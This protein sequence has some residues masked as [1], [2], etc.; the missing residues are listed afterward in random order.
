VRSGSRCCTTVPI[1]LTRWRSPSSSRG[2]SW[3]GTS[4]TVSSLSPCHTS[5]HPRSGESVTHQRRVDLRR[6]TGHDPQPAHPKTLLRSQRR[7]GPEIIG[8]N[9]SE[10]VSSALSL[11]RWRIISDRTCR[12][13]NRGRAMAF[14]STQISTINL[15]SITHDLDSLIVSS[16]QHDHSESNQE[17]RGGTARTRGQYSSSRTW[18]PSSRIG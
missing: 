8:T 18:P 5:R 1:Y 17:Q 12:F 13:P 6:A 3:H 14:C 7:P 11:W 15:V 9:R 16:N 2:R 4:T 10:T